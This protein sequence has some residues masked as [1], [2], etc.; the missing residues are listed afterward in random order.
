VTASLTTVAV[1]FTLGA[2][3]LPR[4]AAARTG[5]AIALTRGQS[6]SPR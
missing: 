1:V 3:V 6:L 4:A 2:I 5:V